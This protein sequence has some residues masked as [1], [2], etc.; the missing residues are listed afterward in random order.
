MDKAMQY[1]TSN[2]GIGPFHLEEHKVPAKLRG[3]DVSYR[4]KLALASLGGVV[5]ELLQVLEGE[6]LHL[7]V[8]KKRGEGVTFIG[9]EVDD[10]EAWIARFEKQGFGVLMRGSLK[11]AEW[12][13]RVNNVEFAHMD[14][15]KTGGLMFEIFQARPAR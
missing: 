7:E 4:V 9:F 10:L 2:F 8:L 5:L 13:N 3:K 15:A 6:S 12:E 11:N 1:Y 14:T